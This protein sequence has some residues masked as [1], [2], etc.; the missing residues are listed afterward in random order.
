MKRLLLLIS[1]LFILVNSYSQRA[2]KFSTNHEAFF[3]ELTAFYASEEKREDRKE[4]EA[5]IE[6]FTPFWNNLSDVKKDAVIANCN[7]MIDRKMRPFPHFK[8]YINTLINF[9][10]ARQ[11]ESNFKNFHLVLENLIEKSRGRN[12]MTFLEFCENLFLDNTLYKSP[13]TRWTADN[14]GYELKYEEDSPYL[15]FNSLN[16]TGYA[17][18]DSTV[19]YKTKGRYYPIE[20]NWKGVGGL[21][22]WE[23]AGFSRDMVWAELKN[24]DINLKFSKYEIDSVTFYNKNFFNDPLM[25]SLSEKVLANV[26][27]DKASYPQF[28]SYDLRLKIDN[29]F[30]DV[31]YEGGFTM[32]GAKLHG[33]GDKDTDA[34]LT[35]KREGKPFIVAGSMIFVI[36]KDKI[37]S[38]DAKVTIYF[39][40]DSIYHPSIQLKYI[41]SKKEVSFLRDKN[42]LSNS[43]YFN[44]FHNLD[45]YF[46]AFYWNMKEPKIDLQMVKGLGSESNA[47]FESS[48]YF[49]QFR[50]E[51]I[52][53]E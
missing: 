35:F 50:Y 20:N 45:M 36:S 34:Y 42:G 28:K 43:P 5:L 37:S 24:Y 22:T 52:Q 38:A 39:D 32:Q 4:G 18:N 17:N 25:G 41:D 49:S 21:V 15:I 16:L 8:I 2:T 19:I 48:N 33:S 13:T 40:K 47:L 10:N 46:E 31:N 7:R 3:T 14:S 11:N 26:T 30:E 29:I 27:P 12:Y 23:R 51:K 53:S 44:S 1:L 9:E 6:K